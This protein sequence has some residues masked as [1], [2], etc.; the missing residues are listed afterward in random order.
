MSAMPDNFWAMVAA[1]VAKLIV[2]RQA[3][4]GFQARPAIG[5]GSLT[6]NQPDA[7]LNPADNQGWHA[8]T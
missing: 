5:I 4:A 1:E 3:G 8:I 7:R 2:A 6:P